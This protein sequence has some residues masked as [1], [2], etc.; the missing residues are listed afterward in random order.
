MARLEAQRDDGIDVVAIVTP[1]HL[2][3]P[4]ATAFLEA[5]IHVICDKPMTVTL[6]EALAL[7]ALSRS[8][9]K[10]LAVTY[11]YSGYPMVRH[12]KDMVASGELGVIRFIHLEYVQ[13][14]VA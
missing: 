5:G 7:Q 13:D 3:A 4:I 2:H 14:W 1:N 12:A 6:E 8:T 9:G 10:I 11:T